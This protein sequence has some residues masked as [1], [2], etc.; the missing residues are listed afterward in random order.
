MHRVGS[1]AWAVDCLAPAGWA[2]SHAGALPCTYSMA[3]TTAPPAPHRRHAFLIQTVAPCADLPSEQ[4]A[5][6]AERRCR[7]CF[8][9][10]VAV[11]TTVALVRRQATARLGAAA[12]QDEPHGCLLQLWLCMHACA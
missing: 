10:F 1:T 11:V 8:A 3:F 7:G 4:R 5:A 9:I 6:E 2:H 12:W